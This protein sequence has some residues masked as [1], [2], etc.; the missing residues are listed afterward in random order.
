MTLDFHSPWDD[1]PGVFTWVHMA[2]GR[3]YIGAALRLGQARVSAVSDLRHGHHA[4]R[5][6]QALYDDSSYVEFYAIPTDSMAEAQVLKDVWE[7]V[8]S[9][10]YPGLML[11]ASTQPKTRAIYHPP[12]QVART[13]AQHRRWDRPVIINRTEYPSV[14]EAARAM[15]LSYWT[16]RDW[17]QSDK[18]IHVGYR[19]KD[20]NKNG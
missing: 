18:E 19:Y 12:V 20:E 14:A 13:E 17:V 8:C 10:A 5:E 3:Y 9:E 7:Q 2:T 16:L 1:G 6:F 11:K 4:L 15:K